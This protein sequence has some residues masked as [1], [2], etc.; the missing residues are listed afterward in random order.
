MVSDREKEFIKEYE[1][2]IGKYNVKLVANR[3][4]DE[5]GDHIDISFEETGKYCNINYSPEVCIES[6][7]YC[8]MGQ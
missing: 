8:G 4:S 5:W 2:L 6:D 3:W 7:G 1:A